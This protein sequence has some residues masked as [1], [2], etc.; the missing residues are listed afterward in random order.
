MANKKQN[1]E[2]EITEEVVV[3]QESKKEEPKKI[4]NEG[5]SLFSAKKYEGG[6]RL[7]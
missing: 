3:E 4:Q 5:K 7:S 2:P 1:Q 6:T